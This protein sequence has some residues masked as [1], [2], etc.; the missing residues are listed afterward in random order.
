ML[1]EVQNLRRS[2]DSL[3]FPASLGGPPILSHGAAGRH[4]ELLEM[5]EGGLFPGAVV[6]KPRRLPGRIV[7]DRLP[8]QGT[9]PEPLHAADGD[10]GAAAG[11]REPHEAVP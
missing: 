10:G 5:E 11:K 8:P 7:P 3:S 2:P 1:G 4:E 9:V 6:R